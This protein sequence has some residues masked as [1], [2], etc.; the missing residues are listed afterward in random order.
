[1]SILTID[2]LLETQEGQKELA[3][4]LWDTL[5]KI[6]RFPAFCDDAEPVKI[7]LVTEE[8]IDEEDGGH[9]GSSYYFTLEDAVDDAIDSGAAEYCSIVELEDGTFMLYFEP[10]TNP[11]ERAKH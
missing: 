5:E 4:I 7:P 1:M 2:K 11:T 10:A 9:Y 6:Q 8:N 3:N